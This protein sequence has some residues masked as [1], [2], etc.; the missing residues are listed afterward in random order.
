VIF[1]MIIRTG[2]ADASCGRKKSGSMHQLDG[3]AGIRSKGG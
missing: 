2:K 1:R 3:K